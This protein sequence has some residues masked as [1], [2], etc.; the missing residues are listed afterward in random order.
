MKRI[1]FTRMKGINRML[2][3]PFHPLHPCKTTLIRLHPPAPKHDPH[4]K[5]ELANFFRREDFKP[6][7]V[8]CAPKKILD[9]FFIRGLVSEADDESA[10]I[11][12]SPLMVCFD[13]QP[14]ICVAEA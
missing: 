4:S 2:H 3:H 6:G 5:G 13:Y 7:Q 9:N 10:L 12:G 8:G 1:P 11:R 14:L